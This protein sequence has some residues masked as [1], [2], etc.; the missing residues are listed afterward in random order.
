MSE[1]SYV[2]C[3]DRERT[4]WMDNDPPGFDI[5]RTAL[6]GPGAGGRPF[7]PTRA[8]WKKCCAARL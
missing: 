1:D 8:C 6:A 3:A 4:E 2:D 7:T 5:T